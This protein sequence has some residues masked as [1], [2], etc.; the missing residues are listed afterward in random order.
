MYF[1]YFSSVLFTLA[2]TPVMPSFVCCVLDLI[3]RRGDNA[4]RRPQ[5]LGDCYI[6]DDAILYSKVLRSHADQM[7]NL[8]VLAVSPS[9]PFPHRILA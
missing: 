6:P 5:S 9:P 3:S 8:V 2:A 1:R 7:I 4:N